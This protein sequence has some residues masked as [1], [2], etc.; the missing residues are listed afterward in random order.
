MDDKQVDGYIKTSI[1]LKKTREE[2]YKELLSLGVSLESIERN[3]PKSKTEDENDEAQSRFIQVILFIA[4]I[5]VGAGVFSFIASNWQV[6]GKALK[7]FI[8]IS[9]LASFYSL[10]WYL[11]ERLKLFKTGEA[12]IFLGA[13]MYGAA[14]FL[15]AQIFNIS[16][17]WIN[18][19]IFWMI[20]IILLALAIESYILFSFSIILGI[21]SAFGYFFVFR[22]SYG[23][24]FILNTT[25]IL[26][27]T[28]L[29]L[30]FS[31]WI[32]NKKILSGLKKFENNI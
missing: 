27:I 16:S 20:G 30:F 32:I 31:G 1:V 14:I 19:F 29:C 6:M 26:F 21:I 17:N 22:I 12:F 23:D 5:L 8:I 13:I 28:T 10:G 15:I 24:T 7:I 3:F 11:K 25:S 2:I 18:G 9:S 4:A